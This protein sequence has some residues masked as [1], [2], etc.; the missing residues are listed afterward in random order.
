MVSVITGTLM[1]V[2]RGR[3]P[4]EQM[5]LILGKKDRTAAGPTAPPTGLALVAVRYPGED[6]A[7]E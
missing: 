7:G 6:A 2:G 3:V 1:E 4:L 5:P